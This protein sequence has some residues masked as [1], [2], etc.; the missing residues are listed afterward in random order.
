MPGQLM[1]HWIQSCSQSHWPIDRKKFALFLACLFEGCRRIK[2]QLWSSRGI[3]QAFPRP[4]RRPAPVEV[5]CTVYFSALA[6]NSWLSSLKHPNKAKD[7]D[8]LHV[9]CFFISS[10][11]SMCYLNSSAFLDLFFLDDFDCSKGKLIGCSSSF[12]KK[13]N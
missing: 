4:T 13:N 3:K 11:R 8:F 9:F 1:C 10:I 7:F 6:L 12:L 2:V 5:S